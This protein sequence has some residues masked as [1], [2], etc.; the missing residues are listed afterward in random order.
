MSNFPSS[1]D[2]DVTLPRVDDN[3][4]E[5]GADAINALREAV[6]N[7]EAEI[8]VG[9]SGTAGSIATRLGVALDSAGNIKSSAIAGLGLVTLPITDSQISATAAIKE[10]KLD[11]DYGTQDLYNYINNLNNSVNTA[12]NFITNTGSKVEPHLQGVNYKHIMSHIDVASASSSYFKNR[13]GLLRTNTNLYTLFDDLNKDLVSHEKADGTTL[14]SDPT[15]GSTGTVPPTNYA[16]VAAGIHVN[17][18]NFSFIPQT[19]TDLQQFAQFIDNS[20]IFIL[21]TR[22]QTLYSNGVSRTARANS[23]GTSDKGQPIITYTAATTYLLDGG[24]SSPV[25][26]IDTGDDII[27]FTPASSVMTNN[28]FD[29]AFSQVKVGDIATVNYGTVI[30]P[31]VIKEKKYTVSGS[32]KTYLIRINGKNLLAT[33]SAQVKI[34]KPLFNT[35]KY[36]VLATA[37]AHPT[38]TIGSSYP[39]LIVANPRGAEVLGI[40]FNAKLLDSDHYNLYMALYPNGNPASSSINL[41]AID[42]T[43]NKGATPGSYTLDT[44][45]E[46][47]NSTFRK[48]GYNYR[49]IA[50]SYGGELGIKL[51]DSY[52]NVSFSII[53]GAVNVSGTYDQTITNSLY[54]KNVIGLFD[55]KD[56]LGFGPS[57]GNLASPSYVA[58]YANTDMAQL[59]TKLFVPLSKNNY[60]VNGV[61]RERLNIEPQQEIDG[62]G[63]GYWPAFIQNKIIIPGVRVKVVYQVNRDLTASSLKIGKTLVVQPETTGTVIDS[64]RFIIEDI[65]FNDCVCDGYN[66]YALITVYDA[67]HTTGISPYLSSAV[68]TNV[69]LYFS[70]D[71]VAVNSQN[72]S[73]TAN[74]SVFK[75]HF[76]TY[77]NQDGYTFTHERARINASGSTQTV[78]GV[79]LYSDSALSFVNIYDVSPK[80]R[81]YAFSTVKKITLQ[82]TSYNATTGIFSGYLCKWNGTTA[83]NLG[84]TIVGK[85]GNVVRFYDETNVDY[86]DLIFELSDAVPAVSS[87]ASIDIQLFSSLR[88]DDE[89]MLLSTFQM[90]DVTKKIKQLRDARQFGNVSEN[91]LSSSA[92]DYIAAP[93]RLLSENGIIRGFDV[94]LLP[95]GITPYPN[96]VY[97]NGGT[98]IVNGKIVQMNNEVLALPVVQETLYPSFSTNIN[99]IYWFVCVNDKGE[100]ELIANTDFDLDNTTYTAAS[101]DHTRVF[102]VKNPNATTPSAYPVRGTYLNELINNYKDVTPVALIYARV[103]PV[104]S[105]YVITDAQYSDLRRF[106]GSGYSGMDN[107]FVLGSNA[108]FR[109]MNSVTTWIDQLVNYKSAASSTSDLGKTIIVRG[110]VNITA[111]QYLSYNSK[112]LF[113]GDNGS[114]TVTIPTG[115]N[116]GNNV[117]FEDLV[118][119]YNYDATSNESFDDANLINYAESCFKVSTDSENLKN[120]SFKN[121]T[122]KCPYDKR[123]SLVTCTFIDETDKVENFILSNC[124]FET[125]TSGVADQDA[126]IAI[127][128]TNEDVPTGVTGARLI[129]CTIEDNICDKNQM[130][131]ITAPYST[132]IVDAIVPV[133]VKIRGNTCGAINFCVRQDVPLSTVNVSGITDKEANISITGNN[134]RYIYT[135]NADGFINESATTNRMISKLGFYTP[136][137]II[138]DN[139]VSW[140]HT[141]QR[142]ATSYAKTNPGLIIRHNRMSAYLTTF[143]D[144]YWS[145]VSSLNYALINDKSEG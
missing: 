145:G 48:P 126:V 3:I 95:T 91:Q 38:V 76:E 62:Y 22:I 121:C 108:S 23:L 59:P 81:G 141:G 43:G 89:V 42:V 35:N 142:I 101:L 56:P 5:I 57:N 122:F 47:L 2:D 31:F 77:I 6:F 72:A 106:I 79:S 125:G 99:D 102:Y 98:A 137:T 64:G 21:G 55:D 138:A 30:V 44:V 52:N 80:L 97:I 128:G 27:V 61:E 51:A 20:N 50:F 105:T 85:K 10:S 28:T 46:T 58:S 15:S 26:N 17:T 60:Y 111:A 88:S 130:I 143:L 71:S 66:A 11:L 39:S 103:D 49:F 32:N 134:C 4:T 33:T 12:L 110:N 117:A 63:D 7:I 67:V 34:D 40:N 109:T 86:I 73:D 18:N 25:D 9:A 124:K 69:R 82:I 14:A 119:N 74:L 114:F 131:A 136:N 112:V 133:N 120:I 68:G 144:A 127:I 93:T 37:T 65:Q 140:I 116:L 8:G 115:F 41:A 87:T 92:L 132:S 36:G 123:F 118:I 78:N 104:S 90:N 139:I 13:L 94:T 53:S 45:V 29:A 107:A 54:P 129:N 83:T 70:S 84:P 96:T 113:K 16:H 1:L 24:S 75:R 19:A 135:G 100:F